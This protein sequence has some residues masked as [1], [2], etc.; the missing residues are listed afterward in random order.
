MI[1]FVLMVG[2]IFIERV[3]Q[4]TLTEENQLIETLI[5]DCAHPA[6]GVGV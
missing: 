3:A 5:L 6:L 1:T 2:K 4:G